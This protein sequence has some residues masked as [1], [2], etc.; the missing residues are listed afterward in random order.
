[1]QVIGWKTTPAT[2]GGTGQT[3]Y[4]V[5]DLLYASTTTALSKLADAAVG[6]ALISG[7]VNVAPSYGKI[8][9]TTHVSGTLPIANGGTNSTATPT[10]GGVGYGTGTAHAYS[11]AGTSGQVLISAGAAAPTWNSL[12]TA[13]IAAS[14]ANAD[15]TSLSALSSTFGF[16]N[17]IINGAFNVQQ[18]LVTGGYGSTGTTG[19][20][21]TDRWYAQIS[22]S[23]A[24]GVTPSVAAGTL[25]SSSIS[26]NVLTLTCS[27]TG[28]TQTVS[29]V[30]RIE[31]INVQDLYNATVTVSGYFA[32]S[33]SSS[34]SWDA[35]YPNTAD[36]YPAGAITSSTTFITGGSFSTTTSLAY[37]TF[38]FNVGTNAP[39]N[40]LMIVFSATFTST[41]Q[42]MSFT[43][44]QLEKGNAAT[45]FDYRPYTTELTLVSRYYGWYGTIVSTVANTNPILPRTVMRTNPTVSAVT[46]PFGT[47]AVY[48][49]GSYPSTAA[50]TGFGAAYLSTAHSGTAQAY[51]TLN[52]EL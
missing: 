42:T 18:F 27:L 13:G 8:G 24:G 11:A 21:V 1:V 52:S 35:Y 10:N 43:G 45:P 22:S 34:V 7:G 36:T 16:K 19:G 12:S 41:S 4:A 39:A 51:F 49:Y 20:Y 23:T 26:Q 48:S 37:K 47:G 14:G 3:S 17:R 25:P 44:V 6:N 29:A 15:I 31:A 30:Q 2:A 28:S 5:G 46:T 40:G 32:T 50:T 33:N 9:L 38:S